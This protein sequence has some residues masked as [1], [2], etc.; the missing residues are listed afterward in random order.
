M[1]INGIREAEGCA[2]VNCEDAGV[3][4]LR[5]MDWS[6]TTND[7]ADNVAAA[8][9]WLIS[10]TIVSN[11]AGGMIAEQLIVS[12]RRAVQDG[13]GVWVA[14]SCTDHVN[15]DNGTLL[16]AP[17]RCGDPNGATLATTLFLSSILNP[18]LIIDGNAAALVAG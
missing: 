11:Y 12:L 17:S 1:T 13:R 2:I 18:Y 16:C 7:S 10:I 4:P 6:V 14:M 9:M 3:A 8:P 15:K 5:W